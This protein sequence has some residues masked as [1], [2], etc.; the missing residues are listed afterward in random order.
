MAVEVLSTAEAFAEA[1]QTRL[2]ERDGGCPARVESAG[3]LLSATADIVDGKMQEL[4]ARTP[5]L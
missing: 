3:R 4:Y 1:D 5:S 2:A